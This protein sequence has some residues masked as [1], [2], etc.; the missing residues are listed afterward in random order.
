MAVS[1]GEGVLEGVG[2]VEEAGGEGRGLGQPSTEELSKTA[3]DTLQALSSC[4]GQ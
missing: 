3:P 4:V 1:P 2:P